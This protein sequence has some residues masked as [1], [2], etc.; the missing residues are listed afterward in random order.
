MCK[1]L[2]VTLNFAALVIPATIW[3]NLNVKWEHPYNEL[4]YSHEKSH[5]RIALNGMKR[6]FGYFFVFF[7]DEEEWL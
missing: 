6:Y 7:W 5:C 1:D 4:L 2:V 3:S